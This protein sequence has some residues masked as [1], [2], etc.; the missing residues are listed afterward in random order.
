VKDIVIDWNSPFPAQVEVSDEE[1]CLLI[2]ILQ[3]EEVMDGCTT[4]ESDTKLVRG[5]SW[6]TNC[7]IS[8]G[9]RSMK[10]RLSANAWAKNTGMTQPILSSVVRLAA[11]S[12]KFV[13]GDPYA[14]LSEPDQL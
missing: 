11:K 2:K 12:S 1:K 8:T 3:R 13:L 5:K 4:G 9:R 7:G 10:N 14:A 6:T